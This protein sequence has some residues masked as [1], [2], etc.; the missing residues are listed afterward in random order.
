MA[1]QALYRKWRPRTFDDVVG[2]EAI[3]DTLKNSLIRGKVSHAFLFA[4]PRGTGKTSC[5]KIFAKALN[6]LNLQEGEPCNECSN[7]LDADQG[8]M[9]DIVEMDAASNNSVD[10]I[11]DLL[12]KVH[13]APTEGKY[14]VYIIDEVHML[15]ISAFNALL[16]T[17]EE[18]PASVVFILATTELQ[19]VPATIIS[20]TQRYNFKRFSNEA[21]V[22]RM[23]Y[24]LG[25]EGVEYED[26]A[27]KVIAQVAD[28]GMRDALSILDQLL[29]FEK[30]SVRYEDA[31]EV[32]GFA[33]QEQVEKL[34]L[35]LLNG[36]SQ[37]ALD[38]AKSAI[39]DGASAQNILNEIIS[40]TV[41][42]MLFTKTGQGEFLTDD[43]AQ[44]I[45]QQ[46]P[47]RFSQIIDQANDALGSLRFTNQQQIPLEVFLVQAS[48][49]RQ[50]SQ[51][52]PQVVSAASNPAIERQI[53]VL[54]EQV[55]QLTQ[56]VQQLSQ[57]PSQAFSPRHVFQLNQQLYT[58]KG[59]ATEVAQQAAEKQQQAESL[60]AEITSS[61]EEIYAVLSQATKS[62][63]AE[64]RNLWDRDLPS[65]LEEPAKTVLGFLQPIAASDRAVLLS[66][67]SRAWQL[68]TNPQEFLATLK[69]DLDQLTK[70]SW[71]IA[72]VDEKAWPKIRQEFIKE[73]ASQ[74][75]AKAQPAEAQPAEEAAPE[76]PLPDQAPPE[77]AADDAIVTKAE[78]LFGPLAQV[79]D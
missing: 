55:H 72:I 2:Q 37:T 47:D 13:Y 34:L 39:Q 52:G 70:E 17:L 79:K 63:L 61:Q 69:A 33:A 32:T 12:D 6:C 14:K 65:M 42:A 22:Q 20:R 3:T 43:F 11:R 5:A 27:L 46:S 7:C 21:M 23:E 54:K 58:Q 66:S 62:G 29:S 48:Q 36:D 38:L 4:G 67:Q 59:G 35:A 24:I 50:N 30:S 9:P 51:A 56:Q 28:G 26:K 68:A 77:E 60:Q 57:R 1:Y 41:Q 18:P 40:L 19:K 76:P 44:E 10:E 16:K 49:K 15:S 25:Q 78:E 53:K 74:L 31:L 8:A 71:T 45:A 75:R 64:A 73:H